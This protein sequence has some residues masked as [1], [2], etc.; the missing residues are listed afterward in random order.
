[1]IGAK[2]LIGGEYIIDCS[3]IPTL[4]SI[5]FIVGGKNF[6]LSGQD[7]IMRVSFRVLFV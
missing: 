7:Y 6:T 4:P 3:K 2:P 1:M 5:D